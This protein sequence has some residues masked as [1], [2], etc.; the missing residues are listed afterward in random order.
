MRQTSFRN[1]ILKLYHFSFSILNRLIH[2]NNLDRETDLVYIKYAHH[3]CDKANLFGLTALFRD[4][5]DHCGHLTQN[6][7]SLII[8]TII[9]LIDT[10]CSN[11]PD[12]RDQ[13]KPFVLLSCDLCI[14]LMYIFMCGKKE[15]VECFKYKKDLVRILPLIINTL[16][17]YGD[18]EHERANIC[19]GFYNRLIHFHEFHK[20]FP[21]DLTT[22]PK[23]ARNE[24]SITV[25]TTNRISD[26]QEDSENTEV[27][28]LDIRDLLISDFNLKQ[29][30]LL[31]QV[32][33]QN[34]ERQ[35][36]L[37]ILFD[38]EW[39]RLNLLEIK[40]DNAELIE[41]LTN[42][43]NELRKCIEELKRTKEERDDF[44]QKNSELYRVIHKHRS[45][46][47]NTPLPRTS[48]NTRSDTLPISPIDDSIFQELANLLPD[49]ITEAQAKTFID[50]LCRKR[51]TFNDLDMRKSI[52]GSLKQL[53]S[54]LYSSSVH[55]L[56]EMIQVCH[57]RK[58]LYQ[59]NIYYFSI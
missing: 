16:L 39:K 11:D 24:E 44:Q 38:T 27:Q 29:K 32:N 40:R 19:L 33:R 22:V 43:D 18:A 8:E 1:S 28:S 49:Q 51:N 56:S 12:F 47:I 6:D 34:S 52:C 53:G 37:D 48:I 5:V 14:L 4:S 50:A 35:K 17:Y 30:F 26:G 31:L 54:N 3:L 7:V 46:E 2:S 25:N 20:S 57:N 23:D 55:F 36:K 41:K 42:S 13:D 59:G 21:N 58:H 9:I 15:T 45:M 10:L